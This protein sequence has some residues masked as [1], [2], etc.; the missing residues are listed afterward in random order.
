[1]DEKTKIDDDAQG[2]KP[3]RWYRYSRCQ[4]KKEEEDVPVLRMASMKQSKDR[5]N[6]QPPPK[7]KQRTTNYRNGNKRQTNHLPNLEKMERKLYLTLYHI[8]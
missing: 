1:M 2:L 4:E 5:K 6:I 8:M 3:K 7:K